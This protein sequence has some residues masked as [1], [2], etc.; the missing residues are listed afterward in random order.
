MKIN[1]ELVVFENGEISLKDL[2]LDETMHSKIGPWDEANAIYVEQSGLST[3]LESSDQSAKPLVLFDVGLGLAANSLAALE[4]RN[5]IVQAGKT[6]RKLR[7]VSFEKDLSGLALALKNREHF[8]FFSGYET[9]LEELLSQGFWKSEDLQ[10]EW[11]LCVGD[12]Q[13]W[14]EEGFVPGSKP[15]VIFYDFYSPKSQPQLWKV[16]YFKALSRVATPNAVLVTYSVATSVRVAMVLGGFIVGQGIQTQV[17]LETTV[18]ALQAEILAHPL[19][20]EWIKKLR[21]SPKILPFGY[22]EEDREKIIDE[23]NQSFFLSRDKR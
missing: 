8:P 6:V 11:E 19:G 13:K 14:V 7:I 10:V 1:H 23:V 22:R 12:F 21:R 18:A 15:E 5:R 20:V 17:K 4:C 3:R 2:A 16:D 9:V